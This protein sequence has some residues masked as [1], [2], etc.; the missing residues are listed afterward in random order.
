MSRNIRPTR[1]AAWLF[2]ILAL[3]PAGV[4]AQV[5]VDT[6]RLEDW[7]YSRLAWAAVIGLI[8]G[9]LVGSLHLC[10]LAFPINTIHI[11]GLARRRFGVW[12]IVLFIAGGI[13]LLLDDW[14]LYPFSTASL[15]LSDA[16][17]QVWFN[18]RTLLV[19]LVALVTFYVSV[20]ISTRVTPGSHCPYA[21]LPG[22]KGR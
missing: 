3:I 11:N 17:V 12:L 4:Y 9:A 1:L 20:A 13:L 22:P 2:F 5:E 15:S 6:E 10:R 14:L 21:F 18:Y 8:I 7:F 19:L 16:L